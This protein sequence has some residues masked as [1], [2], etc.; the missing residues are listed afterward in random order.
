MYFAQDYRFILVWG[1]ETQDLVEKFP[2]KLE[3]FGSYGNLRNL[4]FDMGNVDTSDY[5]MGTFISLLN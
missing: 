2:S 4:Q 1:K 5:E 3:I